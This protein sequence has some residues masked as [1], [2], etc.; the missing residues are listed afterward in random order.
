MTQ[1]RPTI[2]LYPVHNTPTDSKAAFSS[3]VSVTVKHDLTNKKAATSAAL[4]GK[5]S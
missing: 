2:M 5:N 1:K 4:S 3:K